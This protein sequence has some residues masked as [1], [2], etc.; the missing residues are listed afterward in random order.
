MTPERKQVKH[1]P[2][3]NRQSD[4]FRTLKIRDIVGP[5]KNAAN[6]F[7]VPDEENTSGIGARR[8]KTYNDIQK[9]MS[10]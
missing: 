5:G 3:P 10:Q 4:I 7:L 1:V 6:P 8:K 9:D 2:I